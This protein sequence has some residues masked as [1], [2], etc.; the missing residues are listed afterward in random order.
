MEKLKLWI[1]QDTSTEAL[2]ELNAALEAEQAA[3]PTDG[4]DEP[5]S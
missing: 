3:A 1:M 2:E 5:G 4:E